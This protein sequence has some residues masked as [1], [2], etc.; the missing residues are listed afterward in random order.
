M[1]SKF[2]VPV[3]VLFKSVLANDDVV[4]ASATPSL[5]PNHPYPS[6][7]FGTSLLLPLP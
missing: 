4:C 1:L 5:L 2:C 6:V 7:I 3:K